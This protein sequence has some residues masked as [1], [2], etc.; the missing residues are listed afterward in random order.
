MFEIQ[1]TIDVNLVGLRHPVL[2]T[3]NEEQ[4]LSFKNLWEQVDNFEP[5]VLATDDFNTEGIQAIQTGVPNNTIELQNLKHQIL[6]E[7]LTLFGINNANTDKKERLVTDEVNANNE[8]LL[9]SRQVMLNARKQA[10]E[11]IN[12]MFGLNIDVRFRN[13]VTEI[14][15]NQEPIQIKESGEE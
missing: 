4:L 2:F 3:T 12:R 5:F 13:E 6:N 8:Q 14:E 9:M 15:S 11:E 10:C 7:A 1:R